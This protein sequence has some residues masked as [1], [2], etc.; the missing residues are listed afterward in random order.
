M[1]FIE[2][3][4]FINKHVGGNLFLKLDNLIRFDNGYFGFI[5]SNKDSFEEDGKRIVDFAK[6]LE[7][8]NIKFGYIL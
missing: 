8:Q 5:V 1:K 7:K 4:H 6:Y 3:G 2:F